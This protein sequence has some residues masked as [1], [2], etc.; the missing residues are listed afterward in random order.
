MAGFERAAC[1]PVDMERAPRRSLRGEK[2]EC[3]WMRTSEYS[4][5]PRA[6]NRRIGGEAEI[7]PLPSV[8]IRVRSDEGRGIPQ[9]QQ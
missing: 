1:V 7:S 3:R 9:F 8:Q 2:S 6:T 4:A 5:L